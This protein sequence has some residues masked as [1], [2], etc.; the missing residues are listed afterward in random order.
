MNQ[1]IKLLF[2]F[3]AVLLQI[4]CSDSENGNGKG[5]FDVDFVVPESVTL[6]PEENTLTFRVRFAKSPEETDIIVLE[7]AGKSHDCP[8]T[9]VSDGGFEAYGEDSLGSLRRYFAD[10]EIEVEIDSE[11]HTVAGWVLELFGSIPKNGDTTSS[12]GFKV[13]VLET[14]EL[15]INKVR[16]ELISDEVKD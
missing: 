5:V 15:R 4:S 13:T 9:A 11:A 16:I 6:T 7:T 10:R 1:F 2:A 12:D 3:I 8:I 14:A